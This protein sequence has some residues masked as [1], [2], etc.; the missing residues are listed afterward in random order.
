M[1]LIASWIEYKMAETLSIILGVD[2]ASKLTLPTGIPVQDLKGEIR[3]K[4][5]LSGNFRLQC[6]HIEFDNEF[7]NLTVSSE[8]KD[9]T[10]VK[11]IYLPN[12][13][14]T[15]LPHTALQEL[16]DSLYCPHHQTQTY[17]PPMNLHLQILPLDHSHG[18]QT[19]KYLSSVMRTKD[20]SLA[21]TDGNYHTT[22][23]NTGCPE[24]SVKAVKEKRGA[25]SQGPNRVKKPRRAE[26]NYYPYYPTGETT[27]SL[28]K[29]RQAFML[30]VKK[31]NN[32]QP[33]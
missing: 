30:E 33:I 5:G 8:I 29:E 10:T 14:D 22:P 20:R 32:P 3:R 1:S 16:D 12:E 17:F 27:E 19:S 21:T 11:V 15:T 6:S 2:N 24:L 25:T 31:R 13:S 28:E 18:S 26:V 4:F 23:R 7:V 9:K